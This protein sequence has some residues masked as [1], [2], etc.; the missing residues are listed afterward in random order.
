MKE[1]AEVKELAG[2][3]ELVCKDFRGDISHGIWLTSE[4]KH[5]RFTCE[6]TER[7]TGNGMPAFVLFD[8]LDGLYHENEFDVKNLC[9]FEYGVIWL[10]GRT[11]CSGA[12]KIKVEDTLSI[13]KGNNKDDKDSV[14]YEIDAVRCGDHILIIADNGIKKYSFTVALPDSSRYAYIGITGERCYIYDVSIESEEEPVHEDYIPRIAERIS[15]INVPDGDLQNIQI[16]GYRTVST[17]GISITDG[18]KLKFHTMSLP[19]ARLIW[20]CP[21]IDIFYSTNKEPDGDNYKEYALIRLD[22]ENWEA[23]GVATN[24]LT[25]TKN[26]DFVGWEEWKEANKKGYD[27]TLSFTRHDNV[28]TTVTENCGISIKNETTIIE[29]A[30]D[31][32][33]SL[34]GDQCAL[35]NIRIER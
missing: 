30:D 6:P 20:H 17:K 22:G 7:Q 16:D 34:S 3:N 9:Y 11:Q 23:I 27:C 26:D 24:K 35:T 2:K 5:I 29:E 14:L 18:L 13:R 19:T 10:D 1:M 4:I 28:I 32:Y 33:V 31:V 25:V 15:Y 21:Y 12:R 8:S